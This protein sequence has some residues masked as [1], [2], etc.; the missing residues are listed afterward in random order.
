MYAPPSNIFGWQCALL[1]ADLVVMG[2]AVVLSA[3]LATGDARAAGVSDA[4]HVWRAFARASGGIV[5]AVAGG[6]V[7][8]WKDSDMN[9]LRL[10]LWRAP[11]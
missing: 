6:G 9:R 5:L 7:S 3:A 2:A 1:C 8:W 10:W 11:G 4:S